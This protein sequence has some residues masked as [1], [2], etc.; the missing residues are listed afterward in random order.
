LA[1]PERWL[2]N[3]TNFR[4][5]LKADLQPSEIDF[6]FTSDSVAK[7]RP[8]KNRATLIRRHTLLGKNES[9]YP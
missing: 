7:L 1:T 2:S 6:R 3:A 5:W 4:L 9:L 8:W